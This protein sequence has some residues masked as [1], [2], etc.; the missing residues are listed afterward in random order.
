[1]GFYRKQLGTW[2]LVIFRVTNSVLRNSWY[3]W[4]LRRTGYGER[5][6]G[7]NAIESTLGSC[8][9]LQGNW[10]CQPLCGGWKS[11]TTIS[12]FQVT[13]I[14]SLERMTIWEFGLCGVMPQTM[15]SLG[16]NSRISTYFPTQS[17]QPWGELISV[18]RRSS[19]ILGDIQMLCGGWY[20]GKK[21]PIEVYI[22]FRGILSWNI[23][24]FSLINWL[25][26]MSF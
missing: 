9:F 24:P 23:L 5:K 6:D 8:H 7:Y 15:P 26:L 13:E 14:S 11:P 22:F 20:E 25:Y 12:N 1:M 16:S 10:N 2:I 19:G 21:N 3:F 17:F 18:P 4:N